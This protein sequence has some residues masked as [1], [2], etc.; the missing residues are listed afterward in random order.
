MT[1]AKTTIKL[2]DTSDIIGAGSRLEQYWL[3][4]GFSNFHKKFRRGG[5]TAT[6]NARTVTDTDRLLKT[7]KIRA[8]GYGNWVTQED[9]YNYL[10]A[11]VLALYD[12]NKVLR[13]KNNIG[14]NGTV[15]LSFGARGAGGAAAHFEPGTFIINITRYIDDPE[16]TKE[17]R[18]AYTGGAG[19]VAHEYGHALDYYFGLFVSKSEIGALTGGRSVRTKLDQAKPGMRQAMDDL[20]NSIIWAKQNKEL[21][22]YYKRLDA[23]FDGDY[24]FRRNEIFARAFEKYIQFKLA[25]GGIYNTFLNDS[26]YDPDSYLTNGEMAKVEKQFDYLIQLMRA[27]I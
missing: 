19:S 22:A 27:K 3:K 17:T 2:Q 6:L 9:R 8:I 4:E 24:M 26:K 11:L 10:S 15:S 7:Y 18:F 16:Y 12:L 13:F 20:L 25:K 23:N 1:T 21:S 5:S 14:L